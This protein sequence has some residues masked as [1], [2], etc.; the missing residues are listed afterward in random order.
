MNSKNKIIAMA[1]R[2]PYTYGV[3]QQSVA[4]DMK[5]TPKR[6]FRTYIPSFVNAAGAG[7]LEYLQH[8]LKRL[9]E[10]NVKI[11]IKIAYQSRTAF[12]AACRYNKV[13]VMD[14]LFAFGIDIESKCGETGVTP[15]FCAVARQSVD[16]TRWLLAKGAKKDTPTKSGKTPYDLAVRRSLTDMLSILDAY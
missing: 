15:L 4:L 9:G 11:L 14:F 16:A 6:S 2:S 13:E 1:Y 12:H 7:N 10:E 3:L 5:R 8:V